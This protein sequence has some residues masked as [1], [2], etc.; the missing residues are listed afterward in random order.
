M[1]Y[2]NLYTIIAEQKYKLHCRLFTRIPIC[3]VK[4]VEIWLDFLH[5]RTHVKHGIVPLLICNIMCTSS[6]NTF[7][8]PLKNL[9]FSQH[10]FFNYLV[11]CCVSIYVVGTWEIHAWEVRNL[12]THE[13]LCHTPLHSCLVSHCRSMFF[14]ILFLDYTSIWTTQV[15]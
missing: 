11:S 2:I 9:Q 10:N 3:L 5:I 7:T 6:S 8:L 4:L 1:L 14:L 13:C 15:L 12:F